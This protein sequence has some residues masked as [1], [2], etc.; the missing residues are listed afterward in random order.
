MEDSIQRPLV[1]GIGEILWDIFPD[2]A[3]FG[4]APANF[5]C[6]VASLGEKAVDVAMVSAVGFDDLGQ[7]AIDVWVSGMVIDPVQGHIVPGSHPGH[8]FNA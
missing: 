7:Q 1:I 5:A 3:R 4:G 6:S 2:G 8:Q